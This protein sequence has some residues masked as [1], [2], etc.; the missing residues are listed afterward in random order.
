MFIAPNYAKSRNKK[1]N[2]ENI[3]EKNQDS[4]LRKNDKWKGEIA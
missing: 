4:F 1:L 3:K 2:S